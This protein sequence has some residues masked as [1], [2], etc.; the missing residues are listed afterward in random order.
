MSRKNIHSS[1]RR[2]L[3]GAVAL[4]SLPLAVLA[5]GPAL[6]EV[7]VT[8]QKRS[9]SLQ[10]VPVSVAALTSGDLEGLKLRDAGE[11]AAQIPNLQT[12]S[13]VGDGFPIFSLR[14]V[15]MS[16]FSFNQSS[17]VAS[18]VDEVY[19]GNPA[20]QGVQ[21]FDLERIEVLR[22]PQ[23]TL[24]GK[25]STGGAVNFITQA[26]N[27][28]RGGYLTLGAGNYAR[29]E[30]RGALEVPLAD[31]TL[32]LRLAGTWTERDGWFENVNPGVDDANAVDEY[33]LRASLRWQPVDRL[34]VLLRVSTGKQ[35]AVNY[36]I[37][38]F[39][40]SPDGVGAGLYGLYNL[41]GATDAVDSQRA[42]LDYHE[43]DSEQDEHRRIENDAVALTV[44]W[45]LSDSLTFTSITSW[46]EGEIFNPEDADG[47]ANAVV[48]PWYYGEAEQF[49][50]DLRLTSDLSGPFNFIAGIYYAREEI[51]NQTSIGFWT[52]LD[53]NAD[54]ALDAFDCLD[55]L[56]IS[57]GAGAATV[58]GAAVEATLNELGLSMAS[59]VPAGCYTENDFNQERS[60][61]ALY[62][63]MSYDLGEAL[64]LR[65]GLRYTEDDTELSDFS[66]RILGND[67][68]PLLNTIPGDALDPQA[69][70]ADRRIEDQE[71]TGKIG[72]DYTLANG[73][74]FYASYS[75][76]YRS[77]GFNAQAFFD[78]AELSAVEPEFLDAWE[79]GFKSSL[80]NDAMELNGS[81]FYYTYENQQFLNVDPAT[82]AQTLVN[83]D[84]SEI[85][86][87]E[88]EARY[89]P[90]LG[91]MLRGGLGWLDS[92]VTEGELSG[93]DLA[94]N[95]L[96]MAPGLN[97]NL[98]ADWDVLSTDLGTLVL[99][100]DSSYIDD[101]YFEIFNTGRLQQDAYWLHNARLQFD[102]ASDRWSAALW[103]R[104]LAEEEY[105]T[106][107]IDLQA[108]FGFDYSHVGAPRTY[109]AELTY[110][111]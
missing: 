58:A 60:S 101:H 79:V 31:D 17:P 27:F 59:F 108:S 46:D 78:L 42:G 109:G 104:N 45:D 32:A 77:G 89:R 71:V 25:N 9:E 50:Q 72:V 91:L 12:T 8:A 61:K 106:S 92:E 22:G 67:R 64:T 29:K 13:T 21:I 24:Y 93:V 110:R 26:P 97:L 65:L 48:T 57:E 85:T 33:G 43:F 73:N 55:P 76:G 83:I 98:A 70:V 100:L 103:V 56:L 107:V 66:A 63:D 7:V 81:A 20:I 87:L 49:S 10:D 95:E 36:G 18:Y 86:G 88:L 28:E 47:T 1:Y 75:H 82:L 96:L 3:A 41:L 4:A 84:E 15:S 105:R 23:G 44:N 52:D 40:I 5:Q 6:E 19:K 99:H 39:N 80:L 54:G 62:T 2:A 68:S 111:F 102:A 51:Y 16:D 37:Q 11:I 14:G 53:L 34:D 30:A 69:R 74:L 94:G 90:L 38:A 35:D